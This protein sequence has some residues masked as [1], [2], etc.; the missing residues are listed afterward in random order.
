M[1]ERTEQELNL[2]K[3]E[4]KGYEKNKRTKK[5]FGNDIPTSHHVTHRD[6]KT[7]EI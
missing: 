3:S 2:W 4:M 7:K 6:I 5:P 1:L